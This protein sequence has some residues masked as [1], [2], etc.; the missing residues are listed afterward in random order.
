MKDIF[1][2]EKVREDEELLKSITNIAR[3]TDVTQATSLVDLT[4]KY[5]W[6][7]SNADFN[8]AKKLRLTWVNKY[9]R[10]IGQVEIE[11]D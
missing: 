4:L 5:K 10:Y 9:W 11:L 6:T 2:L 7:I 1:F 3:P 8:I